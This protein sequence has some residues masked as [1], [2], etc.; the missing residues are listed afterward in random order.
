MELDRQASHC[1]TVGSGATRTQ[2]KVGLCYQ[3]ILPSHEVEGEEEVEGRKA[4]I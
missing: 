1:C 2:G 3:D 4:N